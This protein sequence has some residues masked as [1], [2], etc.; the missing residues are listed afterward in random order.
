MLCEGTQVDVRQRGG[1]TTLQFIMR[2]VGDPVAKDE[3]EL[4]RLLQKSYISTQ[5]G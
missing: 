1:S 2:V 3:R 5:K 4:V